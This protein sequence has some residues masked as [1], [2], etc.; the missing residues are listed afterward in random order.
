M[1]TSFDTDFMDYTDEK[2]QRTNNEKLFLS[3]NHT[4]LHELFAAE[5]E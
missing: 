4:N 2:P 3:T 1:T 5:F